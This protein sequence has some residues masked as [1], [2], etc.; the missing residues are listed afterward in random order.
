MS[1]EKLRHAIEEDA[2]MMLKA[3]QHFLQSK[4]EQVW[5]ALPRWI[6]KVEASVSAV[7]FS[8]RKESMSSQTVLKFEPKEHCVVTV[9]RS[10]EGHYQMRLRTVQGLVFDLSSSWLHREP[11][12]LQLQDFVNDKLALI[13]AEEKI[14]ELRERL[15]KISMHEAPEARVSLG[16]ER[17]KKLLREILIEVERIQAAFDSLEG[18]K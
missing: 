8:E 2:R 18:N 17:A 4:P 5:Q 6:P 7:T 9:S 16:Q 14:Q 15:S 1:I 13:E 3:R 12:L 11:T 10:S